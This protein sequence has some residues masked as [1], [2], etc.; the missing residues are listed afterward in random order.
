MKNRQI[1]ITEFEKITPKKYDDVEVTEDDI[2][3]LRKLIE[4]ESS[5]ESS[6]ADFMKLVRHG[7]QINSYVGILQIK[8]GLSIEVLP[9]LYQDETAGKKE[10]RKLFSKMLRSVRS[11]NGVSFKFAKLKTQ[12]DNILELFI[13][14]FISEVEEVTRKGLKPTYNTVHENSSV[15]RGRLL[16]KEQLRHNSI[17]KSKFFV[18]HDDFNVNSAENRIIKS[19]LLKL[20][21]VS[22]SETN[23]QRIKVVL[24]EFETVEPSRNYAKDFAKVNNQ[25]NYAYYTQTMQWCRVFLKNESFAS[26]SGSELGISLLFPM[27]QVYEAYIAHEVKKYIVGYRVKTQE[28]KYH[29]ID[30]YSNDGSQVN[31]R[32]YRIRPDIVLRSETDNSMIIMDTKWKMLMGKYTD[33]AQSDIYQMYGYFTRYTQH[34]EDIRRVILLYP[35]TRDSRQS[36]FVSVIDGDA[37]N[38]QIESRFIDLFGDV[39]GQLNEI[40]EIVAD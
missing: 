40:I 18:E 36:S 4:T 21:K 10:V 17:D 39:A 15:M 9:K 12:H 2:Q 35:Q 31:T 37:R 7:V 8:T 13:D 22:H 27:E 29:L 34:D 1:T 26:T 6:L 3:E 14:M 30:E 24:R 38:V 32:K 16:L 19:T 5:D 23:R 11:I 28:S 33:P 25:R 20:L